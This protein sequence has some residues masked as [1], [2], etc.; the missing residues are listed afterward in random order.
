MSI[1][2]NARPAVRWNLILAIAYFGIIAVSVVYAYIMAR[3]R[4]R[5]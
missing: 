4:R 1:A 3:R 2:R 5:P